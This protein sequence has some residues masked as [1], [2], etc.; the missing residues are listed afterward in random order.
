MLLLCRVNVDFQNQTVCPV[1]V[2]SGAVDPEKLPPNHLF[3]VNVTEVS[4][5][6]LT[7]SNRSP[8]WEIPIC[9]CFLCLKLNEWGVLKWI[10]S[11]MHHDVIESWDQGRRT[12]LEWMYPLV[13]LS[14]LQ[15]VEVGHFWGFQADEASLAKQRRLTAEINSCTLQPVTVSLYPNLLCLAPYSE[16]NE[17]NMYYRA[18]I[19]HMR[20]T[21]VEVNVTHSLH[22]CGQDVVHS[23]IFL[24]TNPLY[25]SPFLLSM[26]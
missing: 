23:F 11:K 12:A 15:V 25:L 18:K 5:L 17:Q 3:V 21:T 22:L 6:H 2:V 20:G 26:F 8:L 10:V 13:T 14:V 24:K 4:P 16:T 7:W 1:G 9:F 19:L